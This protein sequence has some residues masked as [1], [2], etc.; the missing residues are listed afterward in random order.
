MILDIS[1]TVG[2]ASNESVKSG[3]SHALPDDGELKKTPLEHNPHLVYK[4]QYRNVLSNQIVYTNE[5]EGPIVIESKESRQLPALELITDVATNATL[6]GVEQLKDPPNTVFGAQ[7]AALKINSPAII[8]AL[9][10]VVEYYPDLNFSGESLSV[11]EPFP[12]L[13]HH[14]SELALFREKYA[15]GKTLSKSEYCDR[16]KS[17]YEHLGVLQTFLKQRVGLRVE[18]ERMR[19]K[20]GVATFDMLWM[21]LKPGITVYCD[22]WADGAYNAYVI[23][24]VK[25][26]VGEGGTCM[27]IEMWNLDSN[28][29]LIGKRKHQT[30]QYPFNGER[31][32]STLEVVPCEFWEEGSTETAVKG[33]KERLEER[34]KMF[35]KLMSKRCMNYDGLSVTFPRVHVCAFSHDI[36]FRTIGLT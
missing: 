29:R 31:K 27:V 30:Y 10:K 35:F 18:T 25:G 33:L 15:P 17:T 16:E 34:G 14:E 7:S 13:I 26:G 6:E 2:P 21:L 8:N 23:H 20:K 19:H 12:V 11:Y 4:V 22:F 24:S 32:I 36:R 5:S 3:S 9:Q 1:D 28:G